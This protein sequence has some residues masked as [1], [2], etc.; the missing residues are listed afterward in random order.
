MKKLTTS[1]WFKISLLFLTMTVFLSL[2]G[3]TGTGTGTESQVN[4]VNISGTWNVFV[5]PTG[6][7]EQSAKV[8]QFTQ[9]ANSTTFTGKEPQGS[10]IS[11]SISG[12]SISF[13]WTDSTGENVYT[14]TISADGTTMSN[15]TY[16]VG[17]SPKGTWRATQV[18]SSTA[19]IDGKWQILVTPTGSSAQLLGTFTFIQ[20]AN[21]TTFT[22]QEAGGLA[23]S[24]GTVNGQTVTFSWTG[25]DGFVWTF[26]G[27]VTANVS[28]S[29]TFTSNNTL[30]PSGNW[31]GTKIG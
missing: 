29:G 14:G 27:Q 7:N 31:S 1:E 11:G 16:T 23:I 9:P 10:A 2:G 3:C 18:S 8:F 28:M 19:N 6:S 21:S 30:A 17:G 20:P 24:N 22:G 13:S 15:G 26:N 4:V 12:L 25:S 5:T